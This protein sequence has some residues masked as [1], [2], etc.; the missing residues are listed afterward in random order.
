MSAPTFDDACAEAAEYGAEPGEPW[1]TPRAVEDEPANDRAARPEPAH[2]RQEAASPPAQWKPRT[3]HVP[4]RIELDHEGWLDKLQRGKKNAV[5]ATTAN[6]IAILS[7]D[8]A[9]RG[10]LAWNEFTSLLTTTAPPPW[11]PEDM[12][13]T[14]SDGWWSD[15]DTTRLQAWLSRRYGMNLG[16]VA[17]YRAAVVVAQQ[18]AFHPVREFLL[19]PTWDGVSRVETWLI[20]YAG[21]EDTPYTRAVGLWF[22]VSA[23]ARIFEPG[24]KVD[25]MPILEGPQGLRKSTLVA[26]LFG[27]KW[28]NDSPIDLQSKDRFSSLRA[29]WLI[30]F[31]E[32]DGWSKAEASRVKTFASSPVDKTRLPYDRADSAL[33]RQCV[34]AGTVNPNGRGYLPDE[35]GNRR[36][37]P[38][39]CSPCGSG[40]AIGQLAIAD[41]E[42][43]REQLWAEAVELYKQGAPW[44]P[45]GAEEN[46]LCKE[47][48][49]ERVSTDAWQSMIGAWLANRTPGAFVTVAEVLQGALHMEPAKMDQSAQNRAVRCLKLA[50]WDQRQRRVNGSAGK[51]ERGYVRA[52]ED[53]A[54]TA[55]VDN[56]V[57]LHAP[58]RRAPVRPPAPHVEPEDVERAAIQE[59][60]RKRGPNGCAIEGCGCT[61]CV[62]CGGCKTLSATGRKARAPER[63]GCRCTGRYGCAFEDCDCRPCKNG[64]CSRSDRPLDG[65]GCYC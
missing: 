62:T 36:F 4:R 35:T 38:V 2:G 54:P 58:E 30:E 34:F 15:A 47:A 7:H 20:T 32:L 9:W 45:E 42:R 51:R 16:E 59:E 3:I 50:G 12:P 1:P 11:D 21:A 39:K 17:C 31:A 28:T 63:G 8:P 53:E 6:A 55:Y 29:N 57:P 49:D 25:T 33:P 46:E 65:G 26:V 37:W 40:L 14:Q 64:H 56:V 18:Q 60:G 61:P 13:G 22:L 10:V 52:S 41:M 43:D 19:S 23:V 48:Q 44:W 27:R 24:C 5:L